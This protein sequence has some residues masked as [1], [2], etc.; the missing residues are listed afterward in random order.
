MGTGFL[1]KRPKADLDPDSLAELDRV[2]TL[3]KMAPQRGKKKVD[4]LLLH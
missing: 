1:K 4:P 2:F 3:Y